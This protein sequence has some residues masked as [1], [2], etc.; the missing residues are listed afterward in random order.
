MLAASLSPALQ[1]ILV[2]AHLAPG[3]VNRL[4]EA[5]ACASGKA[6][7]V[8]RAWQAMGAPGRALIPL[9]GPAAGAFLEDAEGLGLDLRAV[10]TAGP[11][12]TCTTLIEGDAQR[13]TELVE[14]APPLSAAELAELQQAFA[15]A[16]QDGEPVVLTGSLP[17]GVPAAFYLARCREARGPVVLDARGPELLAALAARPRVVKPNREELGRTLGR[18]LTGEVGT[19][20]AMAALQT[21]GAQAVLVSDGPRPALL[22]EGPRRFRLQPPALRPLN[23]IG[24]GDCLAAGLA[25]GLL[26]GLPLHAAARLGLAMA[27]ANA[28]VM[29]PGALTPARVRALE[30]AVRVEEV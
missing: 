28:E 16:A 12:R 9:G 6:V 4:S 22:A 13:A 26:R 3:E 5:H 15:A 25:L 1:R 24:S 17:R 27:A 19:W 30:A 7:N 23:P 29:L 14:E 21:A 18:E 10:R 11:L 20:A 8:A 2:L